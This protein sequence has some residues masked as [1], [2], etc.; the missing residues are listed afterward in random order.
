MTKRS[1]PF[2]THHF[3]LAASKHVFR[4]PKH[5]LVFVRDAIRCSEAE[6][7]GLSTVLLYAL[8]IQDT[9]IRLMTF[10]APD[11]PHTIYATLH[12]LWSKGAQSFGGRPDAVVLSR[13]VA[14]ASPTL[15]DRLALDGVE[16][17]VADKGDKV[18][19]AALRSAQ[20]DSM[21][22]GSYSKG[23]RRINSLDRLEAV[24]ADHHRF[25]LRMYTEK[26]RQ[27]Q[28][29]WAALPCRAGSEP[30]GMDEMDW[31]PGPWLVSWE[32]NLPPVSQP[33]FFHDD[34]Q[35]HKMWLITGTDPGVN[36]SQEDEDEGWVG[37]DDST[38]AKLAKDMV[39]CWPNSAGDIASAIGTGTRELKWFLDGKAGLDGHTLSK[40]LSIL[41]I[42]WGEH[43]YEAFGPCVLI[44]KNVGAAIR[45]YD[46]LSHGGD[47]EF[48]CEVV[49]E[50]GQAD[51]SWRYLLFQ[52]YGGAP[53]IMMFERGSKESDRLNDKTFINFEGLR[54]VPSKL[55]RDV[56]T[57]GARASHSPM[58]NRREMQAFE[59][60][61]GPFDGDTFHAD[62]G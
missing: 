57:T 28:E 14:A 20:Q 18:S 23:S 38:A 33:R 15:A 44:A 8:S 12:R 7:Y 9:A 30:V 54:S 34:K 25:V 47:L 10:A 19:G 59:E 5:G 26:Y 2:R 17:I 56:V 50:S 40:L 41:T 24:T 55:Y 27:R 37:D 45:I 6:R 32:V 11:Q 52:S 51:P 22:I 60:R 49:P 16:L 29:Q 46:G 62:Q 42:E 53:N 21:W 1:L 39:T 4:H 61:Q 43:G 13:Q 31:S 3:S 36:D 48:S 58:G 35:D